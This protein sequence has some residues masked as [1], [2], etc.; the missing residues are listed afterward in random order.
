MDSERKALLSFSAFGGI[1]AKRLKLLTDYF[2]SAQKA[3]RAE[4]SEIENLGLPQKLVTSFLDFRKKFDLS[5]YLLR[6]EKRE[7]TP[8]F[9]D[10]KSYPSNLKQIDGAPIVLYIKGGILAKDSLS[11]GV[12][13]T[14]KITS[15][16]KAATEKLVTDLVGSNITIVSGLA[17]GVDNIAHGSALASGGR[18]IGVWAGGLDTVEAGFRL[19]LVKEIVDKRQGV[20][21]S[22]FPLGFR[23]NRS[24]FPQRNRII[25]GLSLGVLV[26]EAAEDSGSLIT[27]NFALKQGRKVFAVP[28]PITSSLSEG[29]ASLIKK[30]AKLVSSVKDILDELQVEGQLKSLEAREVLPDNEEEKVILGLLKNEAK[31]IDEIVRATGWGTAKVAGLLALMEMKGKI[32]DLGGMVYGIIR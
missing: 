8:L 3:W 32:K 28:G 19:N 1:G 21:V 10:D 30:G 14:R 15:Y 6:L 25:S 23:P 27:A 4:P 22:E 5:S 11:L 29:T 13:G 26:T 20:I 24:T 2:G 9:F 18:T 31:H 17:Y 12:V 16:G 7:I